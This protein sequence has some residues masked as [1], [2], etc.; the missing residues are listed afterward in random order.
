MH[1]VHMFIVY[2]PQLLNVSSLELKIHNS[3]C[4]P[5]KVEENQVN[6]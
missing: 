1:G 6:K 5:E 3:I 2:H 4:L